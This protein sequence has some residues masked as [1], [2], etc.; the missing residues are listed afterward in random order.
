MPGLLWI[1]DPGSHTRLVVIVMKTRTI[2][3]GFIIRHNE[4]Y[5]EKTI[6]SAA[7]K[8]AVQIEVKKQERT[9]IFE[10]SGPYP[11]PDATINGF[12]IEVRVSGENDGSVDDYCDFF[13][14]SM[15]R[16][17][18]IRLDVEIAFATYVARI[19]NWLRAQKE[20]ECC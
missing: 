1:A 17:V 14:A 3:L 10:G 13:L 20:A 9:R 11:L 6:A 19:M 5:L 18:I 8:A 16:D 2:K 4:A 15:V 7:G 12:D